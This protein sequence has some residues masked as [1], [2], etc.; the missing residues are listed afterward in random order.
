MVSRTAESS[1]RFRRAGSVEPVIEAAAERLPGGGPS[2][3]VGDISDAVD[4]S[5]R[6]LHDS[7]AARE[8]KQA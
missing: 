4:A 3:T 7:Q 6:A 5:S 2:A 1:A 8:P